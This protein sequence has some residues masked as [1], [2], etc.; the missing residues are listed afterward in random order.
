M[1]RRPTRVFM[2]VDRLS[3]NGSRASAAA[4]ASVG[5]QARKL[6]NGVGSTCRRRAPSAICAPAR[7][8]SSR[9]SGCV[10]VISTRASPSPDGA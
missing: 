8:G 5:A 9:R 6:D 2:R 10:R 7:S 4:S 3:S 1:A